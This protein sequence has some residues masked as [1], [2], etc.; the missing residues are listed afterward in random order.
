MTNFCPY[1]LIPSVA[2]NFQSFKKFN[3]IGTFQ[4]DVSLGIG[5][6]MFCTPFIKRDIRDIC[7]NG[8]PKRFDN[9]EDSALCAVLVTE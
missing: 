4:I 6:Q 5:F 9:K 2:V 1:S 8:S 3:N 7:P